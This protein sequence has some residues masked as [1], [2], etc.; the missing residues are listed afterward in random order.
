LRQLFAQKNK[1]DNLFSSGESHS[2]Y[3]SV[4]NYLN[5]SEQI[6]NYNP[7][8]LQNLILLNPD[9]ELNTFLNDFPDLRTV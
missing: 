8:E 6:P 3:V 7:I 9:Y 1:F 5:Q 2:N 4:S